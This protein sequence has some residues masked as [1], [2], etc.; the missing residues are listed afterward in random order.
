MIDVSVVVVT[1]NPQINNLIYTLKSIVCQE[2]V[3]FEII[4]ADD[5]SKQFDKDVIEK[6]FHDNNFSNY[7]L[8]LNAQNQGT[9]KNAFSGWS[10]A[11]GEYIK[12]LSPGDYLYSR[13][14][15][16]N[17]IEKMKNN[18]YDLGFGMA[19]SYALK[20]GEINLISNPNPR[21]LSPYYVKDNRWIKYNYL[22]KRD[23]AN[24]MSFIAKKEKLIK[25][26]SML[27]DKVKYA[28]DCT[29]ILMVADDNH[30]GY[31]E[32]YLIWYEYGVGISTRKSDIWSKRIRDDNSNCF[33]T[34]GD[35]NPK[36]RYIYKTYWT[37]KKSYVSRALRKISR[38]YYSHN[39]FLELRPKKMNVNIPILVPE[40][41]YLNEI[42]D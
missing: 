18:M 3:D 27:L 25:Y 12:Q 10:V 19:A 24:G 30:I 28:E 32:D 5:G 36:Y 40:I 22:I 33:K 6:W 7:R 9:M 21:D 14:T 37:Y 38:V 29:Y 13:H 42:V 17:A 15:L 26:A 35:I 23:Y 1:Y 34:I 4:I 16:N 41:K 11:H 8:V 2:N 31:L 39:P 20:D